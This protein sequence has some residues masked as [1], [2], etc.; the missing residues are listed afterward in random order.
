M[1]RRDFL[2][3]SAGLLFV[4][5]HSWRA[6]DPKLK[7]LDHLVGGPVL[8]PGNAAYEQARLTYNARFDKHPLAVVRPLDAQDV[9]AVV[10]WARK[11]D[12][13]VIPRSGGH[14]YGGYSSGSGVVVDLSH[15]TG[16]HITG[17]TAVIAAGTK[18]INVYSALSPHEATIPAGSC[19]TVAIGGHALGGGIGF[20]SRKLGTV[21]DNVLSMVA[22]TGKGELVQTGPHSH[23]DLYWGLRG[24]GG[25]NF[26]IVTSFRVRLTH[27]TSA[28]WFRLTL[29]WSSA[30]DVVR[31]WQQW[32]PAADPRLFSI[33]SLGNKTL[34]VF[35][36]FMGTETQLKAVLPPW[37]A[38]ATTGTSAYFDLM[39][40]WAGCLNESL[41]ECRTLHRTTFAAKSDYVY[42]PMPKHAVE[43]MQTW[44][45]QGRGSLL[46][47]SYGGAIRRGA[48]AFAHRGA[49]CSMQYLTYWS[50][51]GAAN[52]AWLRGFHAAMRPYVSGG[53]Y[54]NYIDPDLRTN[55]RKAYYGTHATR[56][57]SVRKTYDPDR[58][59]RF[60]QA[61]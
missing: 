53:A 31:M 6:V 28:A 36:Q 61:V 16:V 4:R 59:F 32:V 15:F 1:N 9:R 23:P 52:L 56:L 34:Q 55:Y 39:R 51:S 54:I 22:V 24:G 49:L 60:A 18:L 42:T 57:V 21:S 11:H 10:R 29:P 50:G 17:S 27:V 45:E 43:T 44:L 12:V 30:P 41:P 33:C 2:A 26:A 8:L 5:P 7:E 40:R 47:D 38:G 25:R 19:P 37:L 48:G 3:A 35:G 46:I 20:S 13:V 58:V 14:S